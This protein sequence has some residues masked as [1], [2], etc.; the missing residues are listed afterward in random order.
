MFVV[1]FVVVSSQMVKQVLV[2]FDFDHTLI[3]KNSDTY[4][5]RL[6]PDGGDLPPSIRKLYSTTGWNDYQR[7][8]FR[9]LHSLHV[10]REQLLSCV[11]EIPLIE[12]M[13]ELLEYM[14]TSTL[15]AAN[16]A[17]KNSESSTHEVE[18]D[19]F[20]VHRQQRSVINDA[21]CMPF[22]AENALSG[23]AVSASAV[24]PHPVV[25]GKNP[26]DSSV[27]F[28]IIIVSDAN[29]VSI[30]KFVCFFFQ[31]IHWC[32][33]L[34]QIYKLELVLKYNFSHFLSSVWLF[35]FLY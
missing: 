7:E 8:V 15:S 34:C 3:N 9:H 4:V 33:L 5:L 6:L 25:D 18:N 21:G 19:A 20:T 26:S 14:V 31:L 22:A 24:R 2:A 11:A 29:S 35:L 1:T 16:T 32:V 13:R 28:D 30:C 27:Q 23:S 17:S 10:T 12:G